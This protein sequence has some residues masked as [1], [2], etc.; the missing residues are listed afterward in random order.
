VILRVGRRGGS[1]LRFERTPNTRER[2]MA[3]ESESSL[4]DAMQIMREKE[5]TER[6]NDAPVACCMLV[7]FAEIWV[8]FYVALA[9]APQ[10][11]HAMGSMPS[12][13]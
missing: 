6:A 13:C 3:T 9:L 10:C 5:G 8:I 7:F 11:M 1:K 2:A 4:M 12:C